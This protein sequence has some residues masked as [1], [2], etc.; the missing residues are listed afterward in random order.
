MR[1]PW[2]AV[3][4]RRNLLRLLLC[5]QGLYYGVTGIWALA[6]L[7]GFSRATKNT[8]DALDMHSIAALA[9]VLGIAFIWGAL[10][11]KQTL[12][13]GWLLVGS[14]VAVL[15]PEAVH[16]SDVRG[17]LFFLDFVEEIAVA[18]VALYTLTRWRNPDRIN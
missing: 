8:G 14:C 15:L 1:L 13:A 16:F 9:L 18:L 7:A 6:D 10:R 11:E 3:F 4:A 17:T 12:F 5:W 2:R